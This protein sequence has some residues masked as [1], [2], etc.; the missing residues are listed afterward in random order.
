MNQV[1]VINKSIN[2]VNHLAHGPVQEQR[3]VEARERILHL[4]QL[5][6]LKIRKNVNYESSIKQ[7]STTSTVSN[8]TVSPNSKPNS[9]IL[10][11]SPTTATNSHPTNFGE[12]KAQ[13]TKSTLLIYS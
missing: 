9:G 2:D 13:P 7:Y 6:A 5:D 10:L 3:V 8:L 1:K 12:Q 4:T 11:L